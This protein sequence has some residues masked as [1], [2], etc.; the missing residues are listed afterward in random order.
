LN[1]SEH[2]EENES[3]S[4]YST[5]S[6]DGTVTSNASNLSKNNLLIDHKKVK[7]Y[8]EQQHVS[9]G[10]TTVAAKSLSMSS[11][12]K[13]L[14]QTP[15]STETLPEQIEIP[16]SSPLPIRELRSPI[17]ST[18]SS[19]TEIEG[20]ITNRSRSTTPTPSP[21]LN[22][23]R[24]KS[25]SEH[26]TLQTKTTNDIFQRYSIDYDRP[27]ARLEQRSSPSSVSPEQPNINKE[28]A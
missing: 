13:N 9:I 6:T 5:I 20:T 26:D 25:V 21:T 12:S 18:T 16:L 4:G 15:P 7:K 17:L 19:D 3:Q 22:Q 23:K 8:R 10:S 2:R 27:P 11:N 14:S 24:L 1:I 28:E